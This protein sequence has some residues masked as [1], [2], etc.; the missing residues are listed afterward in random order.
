VHGSPYRNPSRQE[1]VSSSVQQQELTNILED[2]AERDQ[3][4]E[5]IVAAKAIPHRAQQSQHCETVRI[6]ECTMLHVWQRVMAKKNPDLLSSQ[7]HAR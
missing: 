5:Q 3:R 6:D 2:R 4:N 7:S 1:P